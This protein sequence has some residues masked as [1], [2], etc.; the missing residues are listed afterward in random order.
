MK[1]KMNHYVLLKKI[2]MDIY[3][4][5]KEDWEPKNIVARWTFGNSIFYQSLIK[6]VKI[7]FEWKKAT[8]ACV[9][10]FNYGMGDVRNIHAASTFKRHLNLLWRRLSYRFF[11]SFITISNGIL[12]RGR[13]FLMAE[14]LIDIDKIQERIYIMLKILNNSLD[15]INFSD[16]EN[17]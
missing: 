1:L 12:S 2:K 15:G 16:L 17:F 14:K 13:F 5:L 7:S 10:L 9:K 6:N 4:I 8:V 3:S 11:N